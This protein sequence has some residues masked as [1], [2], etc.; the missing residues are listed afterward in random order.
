VNEKIIDATAFD[1]ASSRRMQII[2]ECMDIINAT[3]D[4]EIA[5]SRH[6]DI[7]RAAKQLFRIVHMNGKKLEIKF[8]KRLILSADDLYIVEEEKQ[9][10]IDQHKDP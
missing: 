6:D 10:W 7:M 3:K 5:I 8:N 4:P 9:K 1:I 2:L